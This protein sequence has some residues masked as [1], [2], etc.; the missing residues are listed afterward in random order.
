MSMLLLVL[1]SNNRIRTAYGQGPCPITIN[2]YNDQNSCA[3]RQPPV[4]VGRLNA[5]DTCRE[6]VTLTG[7]GGADSRLPGFYSAKCI[8]AQS[9][10]IRQSGC[11]DD[12]CSSS[13]G[14]DICDR[15]TNSPSSWYSRLSPPTFVVGDINDT[16]A[17]C[18]AFTG[19]DGQELVFTLFGD[20][21]DPSCDVDNNNNANEPTPVPV[22]PT[23]QPSLRARDPTPAPA[24]GATDAPTPRPTPVR[25]IAPTASPSVTPDDGGNNNPDGGDA[26]PTAAPVAGPG[27]IVEPPAGEPTPPDGKPTMPSVPT[28][29]PPA[30][31]PSSP[32]EPTPSS[33]GDGEPTPTSSGGDDPSPSGTPPT[34]V[35]NPAEQPPSGSSSSNIGAIVGGAVAGAFAILVIALLGYILGK[36]SQKKQDG[37]LASLPPPDGAAAVSGAT[38]FGRDSTTAMLTSTAADSSKAKHQDVMIEVSEKEDDISTLGTP[39]GV[40]FLDE[41]TAPSMLEDYDYGRARNGTVAEESEA[42]ENTLTSTSLFSRFSGRQKSLTVDDDDTFE[43]QYM[44]SD[45]HR[46]LEDQDYQIIDVIVPPGKLGMVIDDPRGYP[47]VVALKPDSVLTDKNVRLRDRLVSVDGVNVTKLGCLDT[48]KLI[49]QAAHRQRRLIFSRGKPPGEEKKSSLP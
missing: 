45:E 36:K 19:P 25:V 27:D 14:S 40:N 7:G 11:I 12:Q 41:S 46:R 5:D 43:Q 4:V 48:S 15:D 20:C 18:G 33:G 3:T 30:G 29:D 44:E 38:G 2:I 23:P 49:S 24:P 37:S 6:A 34:S 47:Q 26:A 8:D 32:T 42:G 21:T 22:E 35:L 13:T 9:L 16:F 17:Y 39:L 28:P 10:E 31:E 1:L